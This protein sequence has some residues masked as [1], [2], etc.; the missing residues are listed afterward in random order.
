MLGIVSSIRRRISAWSNASGLRST[1]DDLEAYVDYFSE[2]FTAN[3]AE[4]GSVVLYV[5]LSER[6]WPPTIP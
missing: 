6:Y 1:P 4:S 5:I 2:F 3:S